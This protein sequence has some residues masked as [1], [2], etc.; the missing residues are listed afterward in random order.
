MKTITGN[1]I[2]FRNR[3]DSIHVDIEES[4]LFNCLSVLS[5]FPEE[6]TDLLIDL[7]HKSN[8]AFNYWALNSIVENLR[9]NGVSE[10]RLSNLKGFIN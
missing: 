2:S 5:E 7:L 1:I 4:N 9:L 6:S 3:I 8:G 10:R